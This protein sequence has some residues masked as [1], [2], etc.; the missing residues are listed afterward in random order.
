MKNIATI[1]TLTLVAAA[2][3]ADAAPAAAPA[4]AWSQSANLAITSN[5]I[6]RGES[7]N[8]NTVAIQGGF[9]VAHTSG[10]SAGLWA[11][12]AGDGW[13]SKYSMELD[14]YANYG[15]KVSNVD[16]SVG[17]IA[18]IYQANSSAN[19]SELNVSATYAGITAKVSKELANGRGTGF[20]NYGSYYELGYTYS[21]PA[22]KG[23]DL[24]LHYGIADK[25]GSGNVNTEDYS[26][27]LTYPVATFAASLAYSNTPGAA[28]KLSSAD[29][30]SRINGGLYSLTLKKTF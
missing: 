14:A 27:S 17:Y 1:T 16:L 9:D 3:M 10:L 26:V 28:Q 11:S 30:S 20:T 5:Y 6:W 8:A 4:S 15:F 13:E 25:K 7:Q 2:A 24:G 19:F 12:S 29:V 21:I 18:Y 23:L 22:V